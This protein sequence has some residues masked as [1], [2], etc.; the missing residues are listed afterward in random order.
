MIKDEASAHCLQLTFVSLGEGLEEIG[1][2][3]FAYCTSLCEISISQAIKT[4]EKQAY[5]GCSE[6]SIVN[7]GEGLEEIGECAFQ[8]CTSLHEIVIPHSRGRHSF[9]ARSWRLR[10]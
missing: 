10:V 8:E 7:L 5:H 3:A 6:L 1:I 2:V 4:I 9:V